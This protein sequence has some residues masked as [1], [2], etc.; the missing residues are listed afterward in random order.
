MFDLTRKNNNNNRRVAAYNP[1]REMENFERNFFS[2]PF[3]S[4]FGTRDLAEFKTD[5]VDEGD[6][7]LLEAD[8]PGFDKKDIKLDLEDDV[9]TVKAER[10]STAEQKNDKNKVVRTER[11]YGMYER[12]FDVSGVD[13]DKIK[14]AYENGVLK[15]TLPKKEVKENAK[16]HLEIE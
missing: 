10:H 9:L 12:S 13:T 6:H 1:Y 8:L 15:L 2:D 11:S 4:F 16:H 3:A 5:V 7:F 14:A